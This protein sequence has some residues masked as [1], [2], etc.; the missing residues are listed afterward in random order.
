V[1]N[2]SSSSRACE[3]FGLSVTRYRPIELTRALEFDRILED[4]KVLRYRVVWVD[5]QQPTAF[6]GKQRYGN[7]LQRLRTVLMTAIRNDVPVIMASNRLDAWHQ[8]QL[9]DLTRQ[10]SL[11]L[12]KHRWCS[13]DIT[14]NSRGHPSSVMHRVA[15]KPAFRDTPCRCE[16]TAEHVNDLAERS[17]TAQ[18][19]SDAEELFVQKMLTRATLLPAGRPAAA[20]RSKS[21]TDGSVH[22]KQHVEQ[23]NRAEDAYQVTVPEFVDPVHVETAHET[24]TALL[25]H[26]VHSVHVAT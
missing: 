3:H 24:R 20:A 13:L 15:S 2:H 14:V 5:L 10:C 19:R 21:Q 1:S 26:D 23:Q 9:E 18:S 22:M 11:T 4:L 25:D 6:G 7:I 8:P 17:C 16:P 12:S